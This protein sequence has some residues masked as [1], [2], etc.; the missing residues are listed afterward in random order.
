MRRNAGGSNFLNRP[1]WQGIV[2]RPALHRPGHMIVLVGRNTFSAGVCSVIQLARLADAVHIGEPTVSPSNFTGETIV[3][4][5]PYSRLRATISDLFWQNPVAMDYRA[6][7]A[8][9]L[10]VPPTFADFR[11]GR[12]P[13]LTAALA[14]PA[15]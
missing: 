7:V 6:W 9:D 4:D 12:D 14:W 8:P 15:Q 3:V 2:A 1:L 10:C 5:L 11:A 13:A